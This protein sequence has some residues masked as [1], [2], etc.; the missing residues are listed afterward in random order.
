[1]LAA[2]VLV[3]LAA[4]QILVASLFV[5]NQEELTATLAA[6]AT[7][8]AATDLNDRLV[9]AVVSGIAVHA[10]LTLVY[11]AGA[12]ALRT[13][14]NVVRLFVTALALVATFTDSLILIQL[15]LWLPRETSLIQGVL[16]GSTALRAL[17]VALLWLPASAQQWYRQP[18]V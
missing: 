4:V 7:S 6:A 15:P 11:L 12:I 5:T 13:Q 1:M 10:M 8:P 3:V 9:A 2:V 14:A 18:P 17:V 16:I